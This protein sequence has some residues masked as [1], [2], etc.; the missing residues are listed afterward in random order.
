[1]V[2]MP[3]SLNGRVGPQ[4]KRVQAFI[5]ALRR[6]SELPVDTMDERF[7]TSEA[8]GLMRRSGRQPSRHK[9]D[10][11]AAAA[12]VILQQY[13]DRLRAQAGQSYRI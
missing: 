8:E 9:G 11:D 1:M 5:K 6:R 7:S 10:L 12:A 3:L 13:L 2:G 4:A